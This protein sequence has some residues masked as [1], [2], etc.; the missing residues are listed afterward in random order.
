[1]IDVV[2]VIVVEL[3]SGES[4]VFEDKPGRGGCSSTTI[5]AVLVTPTS[6]P[7]SLSK[8]VLAKPNELEQC[9]TEL[10]YY[11]KQERTPL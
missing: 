10:I 4:K 3:K 6:H 8:A 9:R 11:Q 7:V 2:A 5:C 1:M